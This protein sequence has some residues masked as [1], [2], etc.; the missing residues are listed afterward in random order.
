MLNV[1]VSYTSNTV[2]VQELAFDLDCQYINC[3]QHTYEDNDETETRDWT[4][5]AIRDAQ[6]RD[7]DIGPARW[8][9]E[10][11][12]RPEWTEIEACNGV[13]LQVRLQVVVYDLYDYQITAISCKTH[14]IFKTRSGC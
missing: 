3:Q 12:T 4:L 8:W 6:L 1:P 13:S 11:G 14:L 10:T 9:A 7:Q 5:D 2:S